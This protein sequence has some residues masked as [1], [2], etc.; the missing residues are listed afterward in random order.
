[1]DDRVGVAVVYVHLAAVQEGR[2]E[3]LGEE[4]LVLGDRG[5]FPGWNCSVNSSELLV[6]VPTKTQTISA[7]QL[8]RTMRPC[9]MA[10]AAR[11]ADGSAKFEGADYPV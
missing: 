10:M 5:G 3:Q 4:A 11:P 2:C 7:S 6:A 9:V 8:S 1:M